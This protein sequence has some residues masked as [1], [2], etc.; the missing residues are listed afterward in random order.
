MRALETFVVY[1]AL[2]LIVET[3]ER[4]SI[5]CSSGGG[6]KRRKRKLFLLGAWRNEE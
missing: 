5:R 2:F 1:V 3:K 4:R 6:T